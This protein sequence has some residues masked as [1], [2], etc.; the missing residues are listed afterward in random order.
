MHGIKKSIFILLL[1]STSFF[2]TNLGMFKNYKNI[3]NSF[4]QI[5][6]NLKITKEKREIVY[7]KLYETCQKN[8]QL[9]GKN[10][11]KIFLITGGVL[12][13]T[14][15][16]YQEKRFREERY[17]NEIERT[18]IKIFHELEYLPNK[19]DDIPVSDRQNLLKLQEKLLDEVLEN[20]GLTQ[21]I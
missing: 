19:E 6:D 15:F 21:T 14:G 13:G 7:K 4:T 16:L 11:N 9:L 3:C 8:Y 17:K 10:K 18:K 12:V 20:T 2:Q 5:F 1:L